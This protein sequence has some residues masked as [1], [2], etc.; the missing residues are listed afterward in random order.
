MTSSAPIPEKPSD[1]ALTSLLRRVRTIALVGISTNPVRPSY[2]VGRYLKLKGWRILPVNPAYA[3]E[4]VFGEEIAPSLAALAER[5]ERVDMVDIFRRSAE[6]GPVVDEALEHLLDRG[7]KAI[8]MQIGVVNEAAA[9]RAREKGV[10]VVMN[11][12]P[13][14]EWQRLVGELSMGGFNSGRLSSKLT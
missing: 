9:A 6:A 3:G 10:E 5:G 8:W 12:C 4:T 2:Y 14:M 1:K 13:K 11:L 7:L